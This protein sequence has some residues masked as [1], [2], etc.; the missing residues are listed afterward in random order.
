M[1]RQREHELF[2]AK[3]HQVVHSQD[4]ALV[5][6]FRR[7][8]RR[9]NVTMKF[10]ITRIAGSQNNTIK[11]S[12]WPPLVCQPGFSSFKNTV[13]GPTDGESH[14]QFAGFVGPS[15]LCLPQRQ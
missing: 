7:T 12:I 9:L 4:L 8:I 15:H 2:I 5:Q 10:A 11:P 6:G 1:P 13:A 14:S 3:L